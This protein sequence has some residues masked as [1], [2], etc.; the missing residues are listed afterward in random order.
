MKKI[1][2]MGAIGAGKTRVSDT[3][4]GI[5]HSY[6]KTQ[7]VEIRGDNIID[8]PGEYLEQRGMRNALTI[9]S[10]DAEIIAFVQ[11]ANEERVFFSPGYAGSF[12]KEVIGIITKTDLATEKQ[13]DYAENMLKL[14]GAEKIFRVSN[15]TEEGI[16][17]LKEYLK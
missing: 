14:A 9:T 13:V 7:A 8:T 5:D 10:A 15:V 16:E 2:F 4:L 6:R 1:I 17:E 3:L 12:A 11:A